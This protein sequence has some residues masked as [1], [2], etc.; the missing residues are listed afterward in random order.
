MHVSVSRC[1]R[2]RTISQLV[3]TPPNCINCSRN[4]RLARTVHHHPFTI[5]LFSRVRGTR[6]SIF[7]IVLRVLSSNHIAS[8]RNHAISFGGAVVVVA[9]GV[10]SRC[11]LSLT[12][13][14]RRCSR[15]G[16]HIVRT[17]HN[18]FQP[19]FLGQISRVVVFRNLQ[20]SR[21]QRVIGL[22]IIQLR[23]HLTSHGVTIG[24]TRT[25]LSFLTRINCSP[26][27]NTHPLGQ[28][29]RQRLRARVTGSVLQNRFNRNS[30][31]FISIRGR[32]LTFGQLPTKL[33]AT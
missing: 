32:Q 23:R 12:N 31:V 27:C 2:G 18:G 14:S 17:L 15:V 30:A 29:V 1:V 7:G 24:L 4:N 19:R 25:T 21:L 9:D 8:T 3:N 22:R 28:T 13:R 33:I 5:V 11:V 26:I 6:P 10:K 16:T 20:G